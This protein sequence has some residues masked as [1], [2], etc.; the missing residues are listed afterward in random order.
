MKNY[1]QELLFFAIYVLTILMP[2]PA[3]FEVSRVSGIFLPRVEN[4]ASPIA[5]Q[6][7]IFLDRPVLGK[8][9]GI[10]NM[11][12]ALDKNMQSQMKSSKTLPTQCLA[13]IKQY[14]KDLASPYGT[15]AIIIQSIKV[16]FNDTVLSIEAEAY[17]MKL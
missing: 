16:R 2:S 13:Q 5:K 10:I 1:I 17:R 12:I 11:Q 14:L 7:I 6:E 8:L 15:E 4:L 9:I 3:E